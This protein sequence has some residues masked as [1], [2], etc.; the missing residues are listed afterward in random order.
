MLVELDPL[1]QYHVVNHVE[2]DQDEIKGGF[3]YEDFFV[4]FLISVLL[5]SEFFKSLWVAIY[6]VKFTVHCHFYRLLYWLLYE[7]NN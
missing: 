2:Y 3:W 5:L 6:A 1:W 4:E 7:P